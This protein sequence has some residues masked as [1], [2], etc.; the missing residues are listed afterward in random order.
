MHI[1]SIV[2]VILT[3]VQLKTTKGASE[4]KGIQEVSGKVASKVMLISELY[5]IY[6]SRLVGFF[7][8]FCF[9]SFVCFLFSF[10]KNGILCSSYSLCT[11]S[12][13]KT[14]LLVL[15][16]VI[17][18]KLEVL[19][20][21]QELMQKWLWILPG[22]AGLKMFTPCVVRHY[23]PTTWEAAGSAT[24]STSHPDTIK[25]CLQ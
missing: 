17:L 24:T 23:L 1:T 14:S 20:R 13:H 10:F 12:M 22:L 2:K 3:T 21:L 8:L 6:F 9:C 19:T 25:Y 18:L 15:Q 16:Q 4:K 5:V 7:V 11:F